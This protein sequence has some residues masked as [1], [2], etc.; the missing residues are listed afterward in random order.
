MKTKERKNI[1]KRIAAF[2][3]AMIM[4]FSL[5]PFEV[6][7]ALADETGNE[8]TLSF[9][10]KVNADGTPDTRPGE[11]G[12]TPTYNAVNGVT[13]VAYTG[14]VGSELTDEE[15][16]ASLSEGTE[17]LASVTTTDDKEQ[18][19][20]DTTAFTGETTVFVYTVDG[21]L[22]GY[23][24][25]DAETTEK[26]V[27]LTAAYQYDATGSI[28]FTTVD[29]V[30]LQTLL[31]D[32]LS[33]EVYSADTENAV[34]EIELSI[35]DEKID[36]Q[37]NEKLMYTAGGYYLYISH[38]NNLV[39][40]VKIVLDSENSQALDPMELVL[41]EE[42]EVSFQE[43]AVSLYK[44]N[45]I[46][47]PIT[48]PEDVTGY[49][50]EYSV[51]DG[52][53]IS[54]DS[55]GN[56]TVND[57][58]SADAT[59]TVYATVKSDSYY[60]KTISYEV[61]VLE[62]EENANF[63]FSNTELSDGA[64]EF[65]FG[66]SAT[67]NASAVV[68]GGTGTET[69]T[70][71]I[72]N[73]DD[74]TVATID[75]TGLVTIENAGTVTIN[76]TLAEGTDYAETT[77]SVTLTVNAVEQ[78]GFSFV[79]E[80]E[81]A[82]TEKS[83][84]AGQPIPTVTAKHENS[85]AVITYSIKELVDG[86]EED[87]T[88]ASIDADGV[89][90][91]DTVGTY[92]VYAKSELA[93]YEDATISYTL[94]ITKTSPQIL[95]STATYE[96]INGAFTVDGYD[97]T[98]PRLSSDKS[99]DLS[100]VTYEVS[101]EGTTDDLGLVSVNSTTGEI[102]FKNINRTGQD[103]VVVI[104]ATRPEDDTYRE[105]SVTYT[106]TIKEWTPAEQY[107][108]VTAPNGANGWYTAVDTDNP[109]TVTASEGYIVFAPS[110]N[111]MVT[112]T[113]ASTYDVTSLE[114]GENKEISFYIMDSTTGYV[115]KHTVTGLKVDKT[116]PSAAVTEG[117]SDELTVWNKLLY[118]FGRYDIP[119]EVISGDDTSGIANVYFAK[120]PLTNV[121]NVGDY[122]LDDYSTIQWT[123]YTDAGISFTEAEQGQYVLYAKVVDNA[124]NVSYANS[125]GLI[126]DGTKPTVEIV[127]PDSVNGYYKDDVSLR[128]KVS[129]T[130]D[131]SSGIK[132]ISY[133]TLVNGS[134]VD[135]KDI[136][137]FDVVDPSRDDLVYQ[138]NFEN[139][140]SC[141]DIAVDAVDTTD[142]KVVVT[143]T[144]N[145]GN[146]QEL[147]KE[148]KFALTKPT[149]DTTLNSDNTIV[150]I[151]GI[152]C[153]G[154]SVSA[155][156]TINSRSDLYN[157][158]NVVVEIIKDNVSKT[159]VNG[160]D[161]TITDN[162][163][164]TYTV[165]AT[166]SET[167][168]YVYKV[169]YTDNV[170][171]TVS[172]SKEFYVDATAPEVT[173][174]YDSNAGNVVGDTGYF[175]AGRTVTVT[176]KDDAVSFGTGTNADVKITKTN[177]DGSSAVVT[178]ITNWQ[179]V[180]DTH[181]ASYT[182][183]EDGLYTLEVSYK[184]HVN[185]AASVNTGN[186]VAPYKF[187]VDSSK[188]TITVS[189]DNNVPFATVDGKGYFTTERTATVVVTEAS[190]T[191]DVN[192]FMAAL[193]TTGK[194]ASGTVVA[195]PIIG[196]VS[197]VQH[198]T[199]PH[200]DTHT[201]TITYASNANYNLAFAYK[202][203]AGNVATVD[204]GTS[205]S[206]TNFAIDNVKPVSSIKTDEFTNV[207]ESL[208]SQITFGL[209]APE[210]IDVTLTSSDTVSPFDTYYY[211]TS[212]DEILST[213]DL[214][215]IT[216]WTKYTGKFSIKNEGE[217]VVY[218]K[219]VDYAGN[220]EYI[221]S[222]GMVVDTQKPGI[223]TLNPSV[224]ITPQQP[225][226]GIYTDDVTVSIGVTEPASSTN[227]Y[228][229]LKSVTYQVLNMGTV[230]QSGTLYEYGT[231]S[232][233]IKQSYSGNI[234]VS[235]EN[236]N[237]NDV[238][239]YVTA[240]DN[241]GNT[242]VRFISLKIDTTN[243]SIKVSYDNNSGDTAYSD[244]VYY[245]GT[246]TAT[247]FVS[248]R[249]FDANN[250][251]VSITNTDGVIPTV[252]N[253][254]KYSNGTGNGDNTVYAATVTF[255]ADGDYT[256]DVSCTDI[257]N[258]ASSSV[259]Y[260]NSQAPTK[261]T[262]DKGAPTVSVSYNNNDA[263]NDNYFNA[264]RTATIVIT[265]HNFDPSRVTVRVNASDNGQTIG[266][267][268]ISGWSTSGDTHT[269]TIHYGTDAMFTFDIECED[270]AGNV[271]ADF[272]EQTFYV[273]KTNPT[274]EIRN[275]V[276]QSANNEET[277]GF[278]ITATDTN[279]DSFAPTI[280]A[281][282]KTENGFE[283]IE[284][285]EGSISEIANGQVYVVNNLSTDGIYR[286]T[287]T[288]VDKA[289]NEFSEV[290]LENLDGSTYVESHTA[291]DTLISFSVNRNGSVFETDD[292]T[293]Q[294]LDNYYVQNISND[295]VIYE[296][297][298]N[299]LQNQVITLNGVELVEGE[300]YTINSAGGEGEWMRYTYSL[301]KELFVDE[302]EYIIVISSTDAAE[303]NAYSD[304]K[305]TNLS[306][307][308][309]RT[310]PIATVAGLESDALYKV[311]TQTVTLMPTDDGGMLASVLVYLVDEDGN[312]LK[313]LLNL[314]GDE[315]ITALEENDG[316]LTFDIPEGLNQNVQIVCTDKALN[317][318]GVGNT[319]NMTFTNVSVSED[320]LAG[321]MSGETIVIATV[322]VVAVGGAGAAVFFFKRS[323][324]IIK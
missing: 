9:T 286:I 244:S 137:S 25:Y 119:F 144:D 17:I 126:F 43:N 204:Y 278:T 105:K 164:G 130:I 90:T 140:T 270:R 26:E 205:V 287:C 5:V 199:N 316:M 323:K 146:V 99:A 148:L 187:V 239:V 267:P 206:P 302:G 134:Q 226:N 128:V 235:A 177:I 41:N 173:V 189:F 48:I 322:G 83:V 228:S 91:S 93:N 79:D 210:T 55:F 157:A 52:N 168:H 145:A 94:K 202:D 10:T 82:V 136:Y 15:K 163:D 238:Q 230:T 194:S 208:L 191:F 31:D 248:E 85:N 161:Y 227:T 96:L 81:V 293:G 220:T 211:V 68:E 39:K 320:A 51:S 129:E 268:T 44:G 116:N 34:G 42:R 274:L 195:N 198:A 216:T 297:N 92:I 102:T 264:D 197:S 304:V 28:T 237:S 108:S 281:T 97:F 288:L 46:N 190:E 217:Y 275:I 54:V 236:N 260:G 243:P 80:N 171:E 36:F 310:A 250:V 88:N 314:S 209:W 170:N 73:P 124:G 30:T 49:T 75:N 259:D 315:L 141:D 127:A 185:L 234:V 277:I 254:T 135:S 112:S 200:G 242:T 214:A 11:G 184:D 153:Y 183:T 265:E 261:F 18:Y 3:L 14:T 290:V 87:T 143:V 58:A 179:S 241:A 256:F 271:M 21:Y 100:G 319:Y 152:N 84:E 37:Y 247:I 252:S 294:V 159:G 86:N 231:S 27:L 32:G 292:Y 245:S 150:D 125:A 156:T 313:E 167:G 62:K 151:S 13:V 201:F 24:F 240:I 178:N 65:A 40:P 308:V 69:I 61:T 291:A 318:N 222:N 147:T 110:W 306:F 98:E 109:I 300:D 295:V 246:R 253:W 218:V 203:Y 57:S 76:A 249:N 257:A 8:Y 50:V 317:E 155:V 212:D 122:T 251:K 118:F 6:N 233:E 276:N 188:P 301:S 324:K 266:A 139:T 160:T 70:Y 23:V 193:T 272:T 309:D 223:G 298:A 117:N 22:D 16:V 180:G 280:T 89:V 138:I 305:N 107:Y 196:D 192:A 299:A 312:V 213:T 255:A 120:V 154:E 221:C 67:L 285:N 269:A 53:V 133:I 176:I 123:D 165:N 20:F 172:V 2:M 35:T 101:Y 186:T 1:L 175:L 282:I 33:A 229:G 60:I 38:P 303:N 95:F 169:T 104:T 77:I 224:T 273:D 289:G 215:Q 59:A 232:S 114:E 72:E 219:V 4:A 262:I 311:S 64:H 113:G 63:K 71:S 74:K 158:N 131:I 111:D 115:K 7:V 296:V 182:V 181:T 66:E 162:Q 47:N 174:S 45:S 321:L 29:E 106:I 19:V 283:T 258:N 56:V 12:E 142:V 149:I 207:W 307:V 78:T 103:V 166:I 284:I 225:I 121:E 279:F 263:L 132:K